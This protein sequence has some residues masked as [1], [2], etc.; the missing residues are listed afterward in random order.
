M[1]GSAVEALADRRRRVYGPFVPIVR[2]GYP[3]V[4]YVLWADTQLHTPGHPR[5]AAVAGPTPL[6]TE[7]QRLR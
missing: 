4:G 5:P 7:A 2:A 6:S 1:Q 3:P